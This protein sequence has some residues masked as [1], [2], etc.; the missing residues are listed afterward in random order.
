[1]KS[2][3]KQSPQTKRAAV[4]KYDAEIDAEHHSHLISKKTLRAVD[5]PRQNTESLHNIYYAT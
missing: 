4:R 1:M 5:P 2:K 3:R